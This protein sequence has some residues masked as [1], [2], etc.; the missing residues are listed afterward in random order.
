MKA[1]GEVQA[2]QSIVGYGIDREELRDEILVQLVRQ[3]TNN[4]C[5]EATLRAWLLM[6]LCVVAFYPSKTFNKVN[7]FAYFF[8]F[9]YMPSDYIALSVTFFKKF[10]DP[11]YFYK[12]NNCIK[13]LFF[14]YSVLMQVTNHIKNILRI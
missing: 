3:S 11:Q 9:Q 8:K 12:L 7:M 4:P 5:R 14:C 6:C 1:E 10:S 13:F 2:I